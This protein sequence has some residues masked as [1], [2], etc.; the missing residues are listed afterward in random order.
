MKINKNLVRWG[1]PALAVTTAIALVAWKESPRQTPT[2]KQLIQDTVPDARK[3][4]N[5]N[6]DVKDLDKEIRELEEAKIK[7]KDVDWDQIRKSMDEVKKN[8]NTQQIQ[9][10]IEQAMKQV[11]YEKINQQIEQSLK[12][13]D[14]EKIHQQIE[15]SL[16]KVDFEKIQQEI[17]ESMKESFAQVD[18]EAIKKELDKAKL[19]LDRELKNED[20]KKELE[21]IKKVNPKEIRQELANAKAEIDREMKKLDKEK[22]DI[23]VDLDE[24]WKEIDKA[25]EELK[26]YQEMI[27]SMEKEGLLSTE[28]DYTIKYKEGNLT[29]NGKQQ[30]QTVVDRYKKYFSHEKVTIRKEDGDMDV[31]FD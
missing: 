25:K 27:Y 10:Q 29:V 6:K 26:G 9:Q 1:L 15:E 18:K 4:A 17:N 13:I 16:K 20:W 3:K 28:G 12:N 19:E 31:D 7:I 5:T 11:D 30:P 24:A 8:I 21:E 23:K 2:L 22:F 14:F